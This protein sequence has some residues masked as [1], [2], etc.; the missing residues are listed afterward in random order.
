VH[1]SQPDP[2]YAQIRATHKTGGHAYRQ[3]LSLL[4]SP[5]FLLI[6]TTIGLAWVCG[7]MA[8]AKFHD[9]QQDELIIATSDLGSLCPVQ[10][11]GVLSEHPA[12]DIDV[13]DSAPQKVVD[14]R[15][16]QCKQA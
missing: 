10:D 8:T 6:F 1:P 4:S 2:Y 14:Q 12:H 15:I 13:I 5:Y 3:N 7:V 11:D 16:T 9:K